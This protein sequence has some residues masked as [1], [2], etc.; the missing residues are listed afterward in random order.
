MKPFMVLFMPIYALAVYARRHGHGT[1]RLML[2]GSA[3]MVV[4]FILVIAP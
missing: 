3:A 1:I 4:A 2:G